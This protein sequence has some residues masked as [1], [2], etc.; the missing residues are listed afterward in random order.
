[1]KS[2]AETWS[3]RQ[4]VGCYLGDGAR[5]IETPEPAFKE[6]RTWLKKK[7]PTLA[8]RLQKKGFCIDFD[9]SWSRGSIVNAIVSDYRRDLTGENVTIEDVFEGIREDTGEDFFKAATKFDQ[10]NVWYVKSK[11]KFL[12]HAPDKTWSLLSAAMLKVQ[13][14]VVHGLKKSIPK[15]E[16]G[17]PIDNKSEVEA[18]V[19]DAIQNRRVD[20]NLRGLAGHE[21]G[22]EELP[23]GTTYP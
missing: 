20:F 5:W 18:V 14:R 19:S 17:R 4:G 3:L 22:I 21:A 11:E 23:D 1:L 12:W 16:K 13:L 2:A 7:K 6:R 15:D 9:G 8:G 10:Y